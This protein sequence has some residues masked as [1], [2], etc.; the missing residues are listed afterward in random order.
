MVK[1]GR[2]GQLSVLRATAHCFFIQVKKLQ[3]YACVWI[4]RVRDSKR[5]DGRYHSFL[6]VFFLFFKA[7]SQGQFLYVK[8]SF[9]RSC[10]F[11]PSSVRIGGAKDSHFLWVWKLLACKIAPHLQSFPS[12]SCSHLVLHNFNTLVMLLEK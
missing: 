7:E 8:M 10:Y 2:L 5:G 12:F 1:L 11:L 6:L 9:Q 4:K 3:D